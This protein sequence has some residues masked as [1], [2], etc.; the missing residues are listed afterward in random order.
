V[1]KIIA[2]PQVKEQIAKLGF[3]AFTSTPGEL[4]KFVTVQLAHWTKMIKDAG[5]QPE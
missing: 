1:R 4:D 2:D 5:I 3:E